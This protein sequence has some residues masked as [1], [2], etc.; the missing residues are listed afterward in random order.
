MDDRINSQLPAP[1]CGPVKGIRGQLLTFKADPFLNAPEECYDY[2]ADGLVVMR[3]G[4]IIDVGDYNAV[5]PRHDLS[6]GLEEYPDCLIMPGFIDCH[7]H[8]VQS[9]MIASYGDTLLDW[10]NQYTFPMESRF[11]DKEFADEVARIYFRQ[12]LQNGTT[13]ANVFS[14]TFSTSVDAFFEE[15][16]RYGTRMIS[17]KVLQDRN[18]PDSLRDSS[19]EESVE[20]S[21]RLLRKWHRRGRQLYAVIPRFAPTSTPEQLRLAGELYQRHQDE[22]VYMHTHL[23]EA[24]DEIRWVASLFPDRSSYADVYDHFGLLGPRSVLAHCCVVRED[25]WNL[26]HRHGCGVAHCPSSN[27]FLGDGQ[28]KYWEAKD[29]S[30]PLRVGIGTDVGGG[31]NFSILRQLG[32]AYKVAM[33]QGHSLDALKSFYLAT[34]GGAEV[35]RLENL[36]GSLA[37]GY[38]ADI[39]VLNLKPTEFA[40]WRMKFAGNIF[41]QLFVL[42]TLGLPS[43]VRAT[44]V[45]GHKVYDSTRPV[46]FS[47]PEQ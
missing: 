21:E 24:E 46:P 47:Y 27:L 44:Y 9:P 20:L 29:R 11:R 45:A 39:A 5:A 14:T 12:L 32:E 15:S 3:D 35:L 6:G 22:G 42:M 40:A 7:A 34:R 10:L 1:G 38:E 23:D 18:L 8:Y 31:T 36:I 17:G 25:E 43:A 2:F 16:E 30:R 26:L 13:T 37:P 19:T 41:D 33:L 28:F 4:H